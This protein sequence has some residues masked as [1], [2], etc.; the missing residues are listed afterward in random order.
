MN[1]EQQVFT[2]AEAVKYLKEK[3]GLVFSVAT[4]RSRRRYGLAHADRVLTSTTLWTKAELDAI[5]PTARTK[6]VKKNESE[7]WDTNFSSV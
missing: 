2:P 3:R 6:R 5:E 7:D 1:D 4:L